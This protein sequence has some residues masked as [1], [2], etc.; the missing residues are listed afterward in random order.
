MASLLQITPTIEEDDSGSIPSIGGYKKKQIAGHFP[1][2]ICK[3]MF[4]FKEKFVKHMKMHTGKELLVYQYFFYI[5]YA[6]VVE[7]MANA[8]LQ[9]VTA[10][11]KYFPL[12]IFLLLINMELPLLGTTLTCCHWLV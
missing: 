8:I 5:I 3:K 12:I 11:K 7:W 6:I 2:Q 9:S 1:C 4:R 10:S